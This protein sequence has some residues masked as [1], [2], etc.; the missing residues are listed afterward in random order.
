LKQEEFSECGGS[1]RL[2]GDMV[3]K[4][5]HSRIPLKPSTYQVLLALGDSEM[6]GY[7][8]MQTLS[9]K[10]GGREQILPGTLYA[11]LARMVDEGLVEEREPAEGN[12]SGGP[13]RR[14]YKRTEYGRAIARAESERLHGLLS[15]AAEQDIL[16][17]PSG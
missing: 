13:K 1:I 3:E 5:S 8:I 11:A 14:Y 15:I 2:E 10:T 4:P 17:E 6:H 16:S 7:G 9:D 12:S